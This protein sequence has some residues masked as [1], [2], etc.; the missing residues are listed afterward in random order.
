M[1][2]SKISA[3]VIE[4]GPRKSASN[5]VQRLPRPALLSALEAWVYVS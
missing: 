1:T 3:H 4:M 5:R 2:P